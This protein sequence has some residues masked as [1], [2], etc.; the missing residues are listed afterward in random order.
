[1]DHGAKVGSPDDSLKET[2]KWP[3]TRLRF[4]QF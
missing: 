3:W 1:L 2:H 4:H